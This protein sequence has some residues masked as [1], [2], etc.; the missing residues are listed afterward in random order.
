MGAGAPICKPRGQAH[1]GEA[2]GV[3]VAGLDGA[4]NQD[5]RLDEDDGRGGRGAHQLPLAVDPL[6]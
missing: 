4:V 5:E 6:P 3:H 1:E 2:V